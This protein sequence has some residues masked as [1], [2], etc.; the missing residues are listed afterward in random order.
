KPLNWVWG[1]PS[2]TPTQNIGTKNFSSAQLL[3]ASGILILAAITI[4]RHRVAWLSSCREKFIRIIV[5][6][7]GAVFVAFTYR[8]RHWKKQRRNLP[9]M[10]IPY[11]GFLPG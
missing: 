9:G 11:Q 1:R 4:R 2:S 3:M 6:R 7:A 8:G 5:V 10:V